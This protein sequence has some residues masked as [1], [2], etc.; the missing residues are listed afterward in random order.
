LGLRTCVHVLDSLGNLSFLRPKLISAIL[1]SMTGDGLTMPCA[2]L[3]CAR[4]AADAAPKCASPHLDLEGGKV[5]GRS[6]VV[7]TGGTALMAAAARTAQWLPLIVETAVEAS[8]TCGQNAASPWKVARAR[9]SAVQMSTVKPLLRA[10]WESWET[11]TLT[12]A[13]LTGN[14]PLSTLALYLFEEHG[15]ISH[16]ALDRAKLE[17]F[18]AEIENGYPDANP[19]HNRSHAASV[20]HFMH[21]Q[22]LRG[23]LAEAC[24][25][26]AADID[27]SSRQQFVILACLLAAVV[28]DFEHNGLSNDFHVNIRSDKALAHDNQ[29]VNEQ[30]HA[31]AAF[32]TLLKPECNFLEAMGGHD[33]R[34]LRSLVVDLIL[35][36]DPAKNNQILEIFKETVLVAAEAS[37]CDTCTPI[38]TESALLVLKVSLKCADLG[39]L[40]LAWGLH[41]RWVR[42]LEQ[43]F[44]Q[45]GDKERLCGMPKISFLMDRSKPGVSKSQIG[46]F[47]FV[48]LPLFRSLGQSFPAVGPMVEAV[49]KNYKRWSS[50]QADFVAN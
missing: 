33:F 8:I 46:F 43:E 9:L 42:R 37:Q 2:S 27:G 50:M 1:C 45:Q 20:V 49:E 16:F 23:G 22:L 10:A 19:Y 39:H 28:H 7:R 12:L 41:V 44:Y 17:C 29:S 31:A 15:L 30:H 13:E 26:A 47:E 4:M 40:A 48:V 32:R 36:T 25:Q 21:A 6:C 14:K 11:D 38:S 18:L 24:S 3:H 5:L 34:Q 35:A